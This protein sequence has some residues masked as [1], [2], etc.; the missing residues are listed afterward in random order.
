LGGWDL[1]KA[2]VEAGD[3]RKAE[4][5]AHGYNLVRSH[6][7]IN[8]KNWRRLWN[9][10]EDEDM[11]EAGKLMKAGKKANGVNQDGQTLLCFATLSRVSPDVVKLLTERGSDPRELTWDGLSLSRLALKSG[12]S[13]M[14]EVLQEAIKTLELKEWLGSFRHLSPTSTVKTTFEGAETSSSDRRLN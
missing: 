13:A 11:E 12:D 7:E 14:Y 3:T 6:T 4:Q 1:L 9:F 10:I 8:D 5:I 2:A